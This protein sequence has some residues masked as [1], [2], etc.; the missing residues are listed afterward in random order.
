M[1][2]L[3]RKARTQI[4]ASVF[5]MNSLCELDKLVFSM[6]ERLELTPFFLAPTLGCAASIYARFNSDIRFLS[7]VSMPFKCH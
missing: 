3:S 5:V 7:D 6:S 4:N 2:L 1:F